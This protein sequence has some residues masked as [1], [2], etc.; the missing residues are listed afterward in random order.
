MCLCDDKILTSF[1]RVFLS[2]VLSMT[3][4][5]S[6]IKWVE[7]SESL[8]SNKRTSKESDDETKSLRLMGSCKNQ[9]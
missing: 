8:D 9:D 3:R 4:I 5:V 7:A 2:P 1:W 6:W